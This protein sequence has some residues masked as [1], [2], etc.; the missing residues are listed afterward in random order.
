MHNVEEK[1]NSAV[2]SICD[3]HMNVR[4]VNAEAG[5]YFTLKR[6]QVIHSQPSGIQHSYTPAITRKS[7]CLHSQTSEACVVGSA[8]M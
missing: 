5:A 7:G 4:E 6:T 3:E 2:R 1:N 8:M